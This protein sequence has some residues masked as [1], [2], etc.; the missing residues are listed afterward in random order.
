MQGFVWDVE[1]TGDNVN[2]VYE[3]IHRE[4][5]SWWTASQHMGIVT[6]KRTETSLQK[7]NLPGI[8]DPGQCWENTL[9][10]GNLE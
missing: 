1:S 7:A 4:G 10:L 6:L 5:N 9:N 3:T 8:M 2:M